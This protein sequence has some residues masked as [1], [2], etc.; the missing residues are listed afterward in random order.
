MSEQTTFVIGDTHGH[1]DRLEALFHKA[2]LSKDVR[3]IHVGDVGHY[4]IRD[5]PKGDLDC[6]EFVHKNNIEVI[7]GNHDIAIFLDRH[8]FLGQ[9]IPRE[10]TI[11]LI[12]TMFLEN[13]LNFAASANGYLITHAGLHP[14]YF[15]N[16]ELEMLLEDVSLINGEKVKISP[17]SDEM[18]KWIETSTGRYSCIHDISGHRGGNQ[19]QGG[20][21]WRDHDEKLAD[22]PQIFGHSSRINV[23][24]CGIDNKSY[25]IDIGNKDN[26]RLAGIFL[27]SLEIVEINNNE[28]SS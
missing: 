2:N 10:E 1:I 28:I 9:G 8:R 12:G 21:L 19:R 27:P 7:W 17:G 3:V 25:N 5:Y 11:K 13:R 20:I 26:G 4:G 16:V 6:W 23:T 24:T 14:N 15:T 18:E 22:I